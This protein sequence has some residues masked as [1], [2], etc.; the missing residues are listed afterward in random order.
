MR[1]GKAVSGRLDGVEDVSN[2]VDRIEK[3]IANFVERRSG[4]VEGRLSP[5]E[6]SD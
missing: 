3:M 5:A 4:L 1:G 2:S 6:Y